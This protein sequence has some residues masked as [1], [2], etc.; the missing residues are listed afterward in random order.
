MQQKKTLKRRFH[1]KSQNSAQWIMKENKLA[2]TFAPININSKEEKNAHAEG[3][4][5]IKFM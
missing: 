4:E 2:K 3:G 5:I 1:S